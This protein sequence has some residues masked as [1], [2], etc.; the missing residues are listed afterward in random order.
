DLAIGLTLHELADHG[1]IRLE[2]RLRNPNAQSRLSGIRLA[3]AGDPA[4][5][6]VEVLTRAALADW[7]LKTGYRAL[8]NEYDFS[9][10]PQWLEASD[11]Q[12][13][14]WLS[15]AILETGRAEGFEV[16]GIEI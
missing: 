14:A 15:Q 2:A 4:F 13:R 5:R 8:T 3:R 1:A 6:W 16:S 9:P 12:C 10:R 7:R 11:A